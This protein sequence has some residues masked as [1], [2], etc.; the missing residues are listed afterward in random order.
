ML[1]IKSKGISILIKV[2]IYLEWPKVN[3][4]MVLANEDVNSLLNM[5][6]FY[7]VLKNE[8]FCIYWYSFLR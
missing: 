6:F 4:S 2:C 1:W 8:K 5:L 7:T 3:I